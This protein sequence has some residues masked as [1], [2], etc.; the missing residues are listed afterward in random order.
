MAQVQHLPGYFLGGNEFFDRYALPG[1]FGEFRRGFPDGS[2]Q[3]GL[4]VAG[5][6]LV[7]LANICAGLSRRGVRWVMSNRDN[8]SVCDMFPDAK[9]IRFTAHRSLAA[10]SRREVEAHRSPEAIIIGRD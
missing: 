1:L 9:I 5:R 7:D 4:H 6:D 2:A 10:Q 8:E 3:A